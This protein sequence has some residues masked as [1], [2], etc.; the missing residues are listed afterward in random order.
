MKFVDKVVTVSPLL[1]EQ[2]KIDCKE[3]LEIIVV[4]NFP[5]VVE[6]ENDDYSM[7]DFHFDENTLTFVYHGNVSSKYVVES[8]VEVFIKL[9]KHKVKFLILALGSKV[10]ELKLKCREMNNVFIRA[11]VPL[12]MLYPILNKCDFG[13]I[14]YPPGCLNHEFCLPNKYFDYLACGVIPII[15]DLQQLACH[16]NDT[17]YGLKY[18]DLKSDAE[19]DH[20]KIEQEIVYKET[21]LKEKIN[22]KNSEAKLLEILS[23]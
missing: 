8:L 13:L 7:S 4:E 23:N 5:K 15:P 16:V 17:G 6:T 22:W 20:I 18:S 2:L 14:V 1:A 12:E 9:Q 10:G 21:N 3:K 19:F 11:A